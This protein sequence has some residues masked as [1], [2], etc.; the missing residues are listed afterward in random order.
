VFWWGGPGWSWV[1]GLFSLAFWVALIVVAVVLLRRELPHLGQ[2][3]QASSAVR[4]LEERYARGEIS[5]EEFLHRREVLLQGHA[6]YD[7]GSPPVSPPRESS[8]P[9][10]PSAGPP[11]PPPSPPTEPLPPPTPPG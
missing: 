2:R 10:A 5:R 1:G 9:D 8:P 6:A 4:L 11:P 7:A 3:S